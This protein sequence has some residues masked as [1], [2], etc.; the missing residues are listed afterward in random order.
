MTA[1]SRYE[2][3]VVRRPAIVTGD[4]KDL[5]PE[6]DD[7]PISSTVDTGPRV[8]FSPDRVK[9]GNSIIEYGIISGDVT[10]EMEFYRADYADQL[11]LIP[12]VKRLDGRTVAYTGDDFAVVYM[13]MRA[14]LSLSGT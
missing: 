12:G 3:Y 8:M 2:K 1:A 5:I 10:I 11:D 7:I 14:L 13:L 9:E 6:T 4:Y